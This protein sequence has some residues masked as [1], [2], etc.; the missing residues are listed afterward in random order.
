MKFSKLSLVNRGAK[1]S[2]NKAKEVLKAEAK[3][4][5]ELIKRIDSNF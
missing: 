4:I 2:I 5:Q 3:A 1:M